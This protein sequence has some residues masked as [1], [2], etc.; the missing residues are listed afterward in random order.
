MLILLKKTRLY[1]QTILQTKLT[2][3]RGESLRY[4]HYV[5]VGG[6]RLCKKETD[7][8]C[9]ENNLTSIFRR[10][11]IFYSKKITCIILLNII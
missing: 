6:S 9:T 2:S 3:N 7:S 5:V 8:K 10:V 4:Y 1:V 11:I